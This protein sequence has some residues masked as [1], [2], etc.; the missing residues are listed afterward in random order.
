MEMFP[1]RRPSVLAT[2]KKTWYRFKDF[3]FVAFPIVIIGSLG[4]GALFE[5]GYLWAIVNP[6][7]PLVQG[8]LG[9]PAVAGICLILGILRK[10]LT[11]QLL[12]A[13]A[14][15]QYGPSASNLLIFMTPLQLFVFAL[16]VT[17]YIPCVA[18]VAVLGRE[19]GWRN[20]LLIMTFT[21]ILALIIGGI[22]Y[23]LGPYL[24]L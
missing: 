19:L 20:A 3:A 11:L 15:V 17:I 21:I 12:V 6:M 23:R 5:T 2:M 18:T 16:V 1:L 22:A 24:G 9:L 8:F 7:S 10:E 14:I 4:V 13:L